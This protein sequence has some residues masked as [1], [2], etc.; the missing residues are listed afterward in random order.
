MSLNAN[1]NAK[2]VSPRPATKAET[3]I[4]IVPKAVTAPNTNSVMDTARPANFKMNAV[5]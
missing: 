3:L 2:P 4:P 1:P 5:L